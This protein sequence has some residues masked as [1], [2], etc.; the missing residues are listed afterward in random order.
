MKMAQ[1]SEKNELNTQH[2]KTNQILTNSQLC[3]PR[4]PNDSRIEVPLLP[5]E[6]IMKIGSSNID[7]AKSL[8]ALGCEWENFYEKERINFLSKNKMYDIL[9]SRNIPLLKQILSH[10]A[11]P[12]QI[13]VVSGKGV[14]AVLLDIYSPLAYTIY[15]GDTEIMQILLENKADANLE[16][17]YYTWMKPPQRIKIKRTYN[18][19]ALCLQFS[20][21]NNLTSI[22]LK[23][24]SMKRYKNYTMEKYDLSENYTLFDLWLDSGKI[25]IDNACLDLLFSHGIRCYK[26]EYALGP[27]IS[28]LVES[29]C[30]DII[31]YLLEHK[32]IYIEA[33]GGYPHV[34]A[35][36]KIWYPNLSKQI[37]CF[38]EKMRHCKM[39][40]Y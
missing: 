1:F 2:L 27:F 26:N 21:N 19:L 9:K 12:N 15:T 14:Y 18:L 29:A 39:R 11:D 35:H 6:L 33:L 30:Y 36:M 38:E 34:L 23:Y 13:F 22:L 32:H 37:Q 4:L 25:R 16:Y 31:A 3:H 17:S 8:C 24:Y 10:G 7:A 28:H 40:G 20:Q 5:N